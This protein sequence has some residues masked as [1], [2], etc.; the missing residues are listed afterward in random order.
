MAT[1]RE[2]SGRRLWAALTTVAV[3]ASVGSFAITPASASETVGHARIEGTTTVRLV[4]VEAVNTL[5]PVGTVGSSTWTLTPQC[6]SGG[7]RTTLETDGFIALPVVLRPRQLAGERVY[8]GTIQEDIDCISSTGVVLAPDSISRV[9]TILVQTR[10]V[11]A[12]NRARRIR[13]EARFDFTMTPAATAAGCVGP[14]LS[15]WTF[16]G[17]FATSA[18]AVLEMDTPEHISRTGDP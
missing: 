1:R 5:P 9:M 7:C 18:P 2:E 8:R 17:S 13:G 12:A 11:S 14:G 6:R 16:R 15:R 3:V 10:R 4:T